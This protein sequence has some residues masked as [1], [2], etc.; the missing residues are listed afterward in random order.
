[1][2]INRLIIP[3]VLFSLVLVGCKHRDALKT[4]EVR[5]RR[6]VDTVGF[7]HYSWQMDSL[8]SR[9]DRKGWRKTDGMPWKLAI[10]PHDDYTY[11]GTLYPEVLQNIKAPNLILLGVAHKAAMMGIEDSLVFDNYSYWRGPWKAVQISPAR[12][13]IY[14]LLRDKYA[15]VSDSLHSVEH[16]V[17]SMIPFLQY[18]NREISVLPI[19]VPA[20]SPDRMDE[21][22]KALAGSIREVAQKHRWK[23]GKDYALIVTTDAV[24]YGNEDWGGA[25]MAYFGCDKAGNQKALAHEQEIISNCLAGEI[26]KENIR[27]FNTY[28]LNPDDYREYKWTWCGRYSVPVALYTAFYLNDSQPVTGEFIGYSTSITSEHI[29]VDDIRMGRTAIATDCHWVGYAALGYR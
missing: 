6:L 23:W 24:H 15:I 10:C 2:R 9:L 5:I 19:L 22:G 21:C 26:N 7:A 11:V 8:I 18:F 25:D 16:S 17:E 14:E 1:M 20:M 4:H 27:L 3:A 13:E 28:I 12:E 29:I